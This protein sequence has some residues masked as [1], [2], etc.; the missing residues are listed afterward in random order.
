MSA[1]GGR[2]EEQEELHGGQLH[3]RIL[4]YNVVKRVIQNLLATVALINLLSKIL[5]FISSP[6]K[7]DQTSRLDIQILYVICVLLKNRVLNYFLVKLF[8]MYY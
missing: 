8:Y 4:P 5:Y 3:C 6:C 7:W 1:L 2:G